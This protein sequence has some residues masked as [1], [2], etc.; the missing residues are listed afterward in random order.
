MAEINP[1][2]RATDDPELAKRLGLTQFDKARGQWVAPKTP[3]AGQRDGAEVHEAQHAAAHA[4][5]DAQHKVE[6]GHAPAFVG[7]SGPEPVKK[8]TTATKATGAKTKTD[9]EDDDSK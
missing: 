6:H 7:E 2:I 4:E 8:A 5:G 9:D 1:T 3:D